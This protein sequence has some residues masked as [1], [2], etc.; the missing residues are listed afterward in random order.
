MPIVLVIDDDDQVRM[1]LRDM[2]ET[3][4]YQVLDAPNGRVG[5]SRY[6]AQPADVVITDI[7]MPER[8]G[9]ETIMD[10]RRLNPGVKII[11]ISGGSVNKMDY[12]SSANLLGASKTFAKPVSR[13]E[14]LSAVAGLLGDSTGDAQG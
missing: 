6:R 14:L 4:G 11:A 10:L 5:L 8:E 1:M 12:L 3:A 13:A 7:L 9:L 2:L